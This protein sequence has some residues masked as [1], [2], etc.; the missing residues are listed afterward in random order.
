MQYRHLKFFIAVA[1]E[2]H[3]TR[4]AA[5]LRVAQPHLSHEIRGL[6]RE[7]GVKL[8]MRNNRQVELTSA[9]R[10]FLERARSIL[11]ATADAARAAQ[12]AE[13]GEIGRLVVGCGSVASYTIVPNAI[14]K[15]R[16][17]C[18]EVEIVL[19]EYHLDEAVEALRAGRLDVC[20]VH[21]PRNVDPT[22]HVD[23]IIT[24][25]LTVALPNR[26]PLTKSQAIKLN[27]LRTE[28]WIFWHREIA[29]RAYDE[30]LSACA[31]EGF[32]PRVAQRTTRLSTVMC[33]VG[34]GIG[35][36]LVPE[37]AAMLQIK[38]IVLRR[39]REPQ[40]KIP[41][42]IVAR[43]NHKAPALNHFISALHDSA[44]SIKSS[45]ATR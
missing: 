36:S 37:S 5:R 31:A 29:S 35:L 18:P 12:R 30:I 9:G 39:L 23:P 4:A 40:I 1:E 20:I 8:F 42:S 10:I 15:V 7:I 6:E 13:R 41:L 19:T 26:H 2:L 11:D 33:L 16:R 44:K 24:D 17:S 45:M 38:G 21:P 25:P 3:F 28:P 32:E 43:S 34:S 14:A 22:L 27:H